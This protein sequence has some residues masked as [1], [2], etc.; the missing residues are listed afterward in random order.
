LQLPGLMPSPVGHSVFGALC[1]KVAPA[2]RVP[3]W[4][5]YGLGLLAAN[6]P[7]L[8]FL[9]GIL[10]G[11]VNRYHRSAS[12]SITAA[13]VFGVACWLIMRA[14]RRT[15]E[16]ARALGVLSV[17]AYSSHLVL[18]ALSQGSNGRPSGQRLFWPF[19]TD[20]VFFGWAPIPAFH[21]GSA[22]DSLGSVVG[23]IVTWHNFQTMVWE[24][25]VLAPVALLIWLVL[26]HDLLA[27]VLGGSGR[28][29]HGLPTRK[30]AETDDP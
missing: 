28:R 24:V 3:R 25:V 30:M 11:D 4:A 19:S 8:D 5:W 26:H 1:C 16:S 9:A 18:D 17:L 15:R 21:H 20:L 14:S 13:V 29:G 7:D 2:A 22:G 12:H 27:R 6:A 23:S 10:V